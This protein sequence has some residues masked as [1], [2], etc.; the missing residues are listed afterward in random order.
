[1]QRTKIEYLDYSW[2]PFQMRCDRVS[3]GCKNCWALEMA[4]RFNYPQQIVLK[5]PSP[6]FPKKSARI[7]VQFMGDLFHEGINEED[8]DDIIATACISPDHKFIFLTKRIKRARDF[9]DSYAWQLEDNIWLGVSV[10]NQRTA[11]ERIPILLSIPARVRFVSVEPMLEEIDIQKWHG[12]DWVICG[13]ESGHNRRKCEPEWIID[14]LSQCSADGIP[15]FLKQMEID[16]KVVK[17]PELDGRIWNEY[18]KK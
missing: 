11:D 8:I 17:M 15:F 12:I 1:M 9:I 13:C 6:K 16:G 2:N 3:E 4:N 18:P 5:E 14:L 7:G 10:E